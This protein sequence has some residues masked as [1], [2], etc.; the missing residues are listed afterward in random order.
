MTPKRGFDKEELKFLLNAP[1][2]PP[3]LTRENAVVSE[4]TIR[5][6]DFTPIG[7]CGQSSTPR[8][9]KRKLK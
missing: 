5:R 1:I 4:T 6:L 9:K 7:I 3:K 8:R 2:K